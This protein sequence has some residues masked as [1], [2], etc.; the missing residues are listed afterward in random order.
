MTN[1]EFKIYFYETDLGC[2]ICIDTKRPYIVIKG[3]NLV[4]KTVSLK[5]SFSDKY[6]ALE[7]LKS[8]T[9]R[10]VELELD[11]NTESKKGKMC[12]DEYTD[13][14]YSLHKSEIKYQSKFTECFDWF[15]TYEDLYLNEY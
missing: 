1:T 8:L 5:K 2:G 15:I 13:V 3:I 7:Y 11:I 9:Y 14:F 10:D 4:K 6:E 12:A